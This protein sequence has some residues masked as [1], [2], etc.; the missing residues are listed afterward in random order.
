VPLEG[1]AHG[2]GT[3]VLQQR[4]E[5]LLV[6]EGECAT[7]QIDARRSRRAGWACALASG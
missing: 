7:V 1:V 6:D 2:V 4:D 5:L 3:D